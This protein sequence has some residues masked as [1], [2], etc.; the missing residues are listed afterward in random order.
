MLNIT[1]TT[2]NSDVNVKKKKEEYCGSSTTIYLR[3]KYKSCRQKTSS[4]GAEFFFRLLVEQWKDKYTVADH[5]MCK[6]FLLQH[7]NGRWKGSMLKRR[8]PRAIY[9]EGIQSYRDH[10]YYSVSCVQWI[11]YADWLFEEQMYIFLYLLHLLINNYIWLGKIAAV[12]VL[13]LW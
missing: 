8:H 1:T 12:I 4:V 11:D 3:E 9:N 5:Y 10:Q 13:Y 7:V 6:R 2:I